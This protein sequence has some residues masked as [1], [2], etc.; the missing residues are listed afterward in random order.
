MEEKKFRILHQGQLCRK[1]V[2]LPFLKGE[3]EIVF[4]FG[5]DS[6]GYLL[7]FAKISWQI[8]GKPDLVIHYHLRQETN[9]PIYFWSGR[10]EFWKD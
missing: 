10:L 6:A 3:E 2:V 1:A 9:I 8:S 7:L 4:G 5:I